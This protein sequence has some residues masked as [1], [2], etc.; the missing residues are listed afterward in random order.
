MKNKYLIGGFLAV[1]IT[2]LGIYLFLSLTE[3]IEETQKYNEKKI[4]IIEKPID[5]S[6]LD[7]E[8]LTES[9]L[10]STRDS[11]ASIGFNGKMWVYGGVDGGNTFTGAYEVLEHKSDTWVSGN[12]I[13]WEF[14]RDELPP[15][16]RGMM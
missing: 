11:H 9:A 16:E 4:V 2:I 15:L 3:N 10:W 13:D 1:L 5:L 8:A 12:G 14:V 7:W 6:M